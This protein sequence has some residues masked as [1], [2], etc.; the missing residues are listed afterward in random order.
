[1]A[2]MMIAT[3]YERGKH[4]GFKL[5]DV[6]SR[7]VRNVSYDSVA[8][9]LGRGS[10]VDN[11]ELRDG[12]IVAT[13]G[14]IDDYTKIEA[15]VP[16]SRVSIV[17]LKKE[18]DGKYLVSTWNGDTVKLTES[19]IIEYCEKIGLANGKIVS[20]PYGKG[21]KA[22]EKRLLFANETYE[23]VLLRFEQEKQQHYNELYSRVEG[24]NT[25]FDAL[26]S[27]YY[28]TEQLELRVSNR[29]TFN[30]KLVKIHDIV[31]IMPREDFRY[32]LSINEVIGGSNLHD[33]GNGCFL[34]CANL[35]KVDLSKTKLS[36][37]PYG[38]FANCAALKELSLPD[39][40]KTIGGKS[41]SNC[42]IEE[43]ILPAGTKQILDAAFMDCGKL[44]NIAWNS[45][46]R[47]IGYGAFANTG[48]EEV[49]IPDSVNMIDDLAFGNC[50]KLNYIYIPNSVKSL[51]Y[52]F[53]RGFR[54]ELVIPKRLFTTAMR[55]KL[56]SNVKVKTY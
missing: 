13:T 20:V 41:F 36:E 17:V 42:G 43:L 33:L 29:N 9:L 7:Q 26:G 30:D 12:K 38:A 2:I 34:G 39:T 24:V 56:S 48:I 14:D 52:L 16:L 50:S 18:Y 35:E 10:R 4:L 22:I 44:K 11:I 15:D 3:I 21:S 37:I 40:I 49:I 46:I 27:E 23:D 51:S 53:A 47:F 45:E 1:M 55:K 54:G 6:E 5:I 19:E 32:L 8:S 31:K 25:K 28:I